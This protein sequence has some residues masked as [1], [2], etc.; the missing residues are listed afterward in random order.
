MKRRQV[1]V[2]AEQFSTVGIEVCMGGGQGWTGV[3]VAKG[4]VNKLTQ[5]WTHQPPRLSLSVRGKRR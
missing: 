3:A 5:A 2:K 4:T 1:E